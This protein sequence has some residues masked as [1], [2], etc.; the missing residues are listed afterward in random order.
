MS[1]LIDRISQYYEELGGDRAGALST[2]P[3]NRLEWY[4]QTHFQGQE[5]RSVETGCGAS[6]IVFA[7]H[8]AHHTV[9]C[10]DDRSEIGSSVNY[11]QN[12][13]GCRHDQVKWIC[14]P[15]QRPIVFAEPL[16]P[17]VD[18]AL[19]DG[20]HGYPFP[21]LEYFALY[22]WLKPGGILI[23]DDI[24]IPTINNLHRFLLQDD[25]F[26]SHGAALTNSLFRADAQPGLQHRG[27]RLV[28]PA[29]QRAELPSPACE[30]TDPGRAASHLRSVRSEAGHRLRSR[31]SQFGG[32]SGHLAATRRRPNGFAS[33]RRAVV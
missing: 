1:D 20:P 26:R 25:S 6:T 19:I 10:Y 7:Q 28:A 8:S 5:V 9:S 12:F 4:L 32:I 17:P 15:T 14:G 30:P 2:L 13:P 31:Q 16:T 24:H 3:L 33:R 29:I 18:I 22:R 21:E 23:V 11:A 27:R